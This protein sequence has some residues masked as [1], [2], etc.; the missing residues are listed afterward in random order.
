[1]CY[2]I[3]VSITTVGYGDFAPRTVIGR[4]FTSVFIVAGVL[5]LF[6][7]QVEF[8]KAWAE[9]HEGSGVYQAKPRKRGSLQ[10]HVVV[11]LCTRRRAVHFSSMLAG[12]LREILH[13]ERSHEW[14]DVVIFSRTPWDV[15]GDGEESQGSTFDDF[16]RAEGL[17]ASVRRRVL[18]IVGKLSSKADMERAAIGQ[19]LA[20]LLADV[21]SETP[22]REDEDNLFTA[23]LMRQFFPD[24]QLRVMLLRPQ[25]KEL[26][27]QAGIEISR[28]FSL[29]ELKA[30]ILAQNV[31]CHGLVPMITGMLLSVDVREEA[32]GL[33]RASGRGT[34]A[35]DRSTHDGAVPEEAHGSPPVSPHYEARP[36]AYSGSSSSRSSSSAGPGVGPRHSGSMRSRA[37]TQSASSVASSIRAGQRALWT[38][39]RDSSAWKEKVSPWVLDYIE[40]LQ[41]SVFGFELSEDLAG[42]SFGEI[43]TAVFSRTGAIVFATFVNCQLLICPQDVSEAEERQIFFAVAKDESTLKGC[44]TAEF[45]ADNWRRSLLMARHLERRKTRQG[46]H[47]SASKL[48]GHSLRRAMVWRSGRFTPEPGAI[49]RQQSPLSLP[50][51]PMAPINGGAP[52]QREMGSSLESVHSYG[53]GREVSLREQQRRLQYLRSQL[54]HTGEELVVVIVC[55]GEVWQQVRTFVASLCAPHLPDRRPIVVFAPTKM[56]RQLLDDDL[57]GQVLVVEGNCTKVKSLIEAGVL[58][59]SAVVVMSGQAPAAEG[60]ETLHQD[61]RIVLCAQ[62]LECWCGMS[63]HEVY[64]TYELQHSG[65]VRKLPKILQKSFASMEDLLSGRPHDYHVGQEPDTAAAGERRFS[66]IASA[67][68][69]QSGASSAAEFTEPEG[70]VTDTRSR[71]DARTRDADESISAMY[72]P[73]FAA[74]QIFTPELWGAMLGYMYYMPA[75]IELVEALVMPHKRE[76][77]AYPWQICVPT[78]HVG[79]KFGELFSDLALEGI[80]TRLAAAEAQAPPGAGAGPGPREEDEVYSLGPAVALALHRRREET[81]SLAPGTGGH[82]YTILAP[83]PSTRLRADDWVVVLGSAAF[84]RHMCRVGL[85]RGSGEAAHRADGDEL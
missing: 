50:Y 5:Y 42:L 24:A 6:M 46:P 2:W 79:R 60:R 84:G 65:S 7:V 55:Q 12:F 83:P 33:L 57:D 35:P 76:Q 34:G 36:S 22:D 68:S 48:L 71:G 27:V 41:R 16:L 66:S 51:T 56:P 72:H 17:S 21:A 38:R 67:N 85:L 18:F 53:G 25:S 8:M 58:E 77:H 45:P 75:I 9:I 82:N 52:L 64:A 29:Q 69:S 70:G 26:A 74:G 47:V 37:S 19:S 30:N 13:T 63:G 23:V 49:S 80:Q 39:F 81:L 44:R 1:M 62:I 20:F 3:V 14:P 15:A 54:A 59:A 11:V 43:A 32:R 61:S 78:A 31:R 4:F 28:C 40:G 10:R 73:R